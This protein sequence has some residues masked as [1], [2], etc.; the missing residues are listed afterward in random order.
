MFESISI[1]IVIACILLTFL[2]IYFFLGTCLSF[3]NE[4]LEGNL[5]WGII[6]FITGFLIICLSSL[7][8]YQKKNGVPLGSGFDV[9][10]LINGALIFSVLLTV[11]IKKRKKI[12]QEDYNRVLYKSF[13]EKIIKFAIVKK[14]FTEKEYHDFIETEII[15]ETPYQGYG[16]PQYSHFADNPNYEV[17]IEAAQRFAYSYPKTFIINDILK[18]RK[19]TKNNTTRK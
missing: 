9:F 4:D 5:S 15:S 14:E 12:K 17:Y 2:L 16:K 10:T 13:Y 18:S 19:R 7:I 8:I 3:Y 1:A 6:S 11:Y